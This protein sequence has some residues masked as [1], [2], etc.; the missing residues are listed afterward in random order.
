MVERSFKHNVENLENVGMF[1]KMYTWSSYVKLFLAIGHRKAKS[2]K[3]LAHKCFNNQIIQY[4]R[5]NNLDS[6]F[7]F[8]TKQFEKL[9]NC[10]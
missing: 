8:Y 5:Y 9:S 6:S 4:N 10:K 1:K 2:S 3:H 7:F